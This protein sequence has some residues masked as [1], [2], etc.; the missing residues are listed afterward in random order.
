MKEQFD[1]YRVQVHKV[2]SRVILFMFAIDTGE[3]PLIV[4]GGPICT[5]CPF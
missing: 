1:G 4:L 2:G 5:S 3:R